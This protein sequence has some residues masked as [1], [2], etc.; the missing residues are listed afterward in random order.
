MKYTS[1]NHGAYKAALAVDDGKGGVS[2][3]D[4]EILAGNE[5]P[6]L[7]F[8][9]E[10][11][12]TFFFPGSSFNYE[13]KVSDK[14]DGTL[15]NGITP[16]E[17][18]V[19]IDYL[20]E[21]FD[22]TQIVQGHLSAD[23]NAEFIKGKSLMDNSDCKSCHLTDKKSIG[24]M[25]VDVAK[26]YKNDPKAVDYLA[27]K[28]INGGGGVWGDVNMAAH[29]QISMADA[30]EMVKYVLT[31]DEVKT[32]PGLPVKGSYT[33]AI[34]K[35]VSEGGVF[36]L[37]ASYADRGANGIPSARSEQSLVL[38]NA[39][40]EA[41]TADFVE[42]IQKFKMGDMPTFM[43]GQADGAYIGF[44]KLDLTGISQVTFVASAPQQ[45]G[46]TGGKIEIRLDSPTGELVGES[47]VIKPAMGSGQAPA[48]P[49]IVSAKLK[50]T[51]GFHDIYF[52]LKNPDAASGQSLFVLLTIQFGANGAKQLSM[53]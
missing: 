12:Q 30:T 8:D 13:V 48:A 47:S 6:Q 41:G 49:S 34:K 5:P 50:P 1:D 7:S 11:N 26:K 2:T 23:A 9:I 39:S 20:P 25:Y 3:R 24:P 10:G 35:G 37:R 44:R 28:I 53:N 40:I 52:I 43:I 22:K 42:S 29:P 33:T 16:E 51:E 14:E 27:K 38:R 45:Y 36:L 19:N 17:I 4:L 32:K 15:G 46:M 21:G 31:L 18:S